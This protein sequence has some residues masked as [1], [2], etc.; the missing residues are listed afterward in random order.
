MKKN[1][2]TITVTIHKLERLRSIKR[3]E[4]K[5]RVVLREEEVFVKKLT[6]KYEKIL[7]QK[8]EISKQIKILRIK[9]ETSKV[10][11]VIGT[12]SN[13]IFKLEKQEKKIEK[14]TKK[15]KLTIDLITSQ[16][17]PSP[18]HSLTETEKSIVHILKSKMSKSIITKMNKLRI[19]L[20]TLKLQL[21]H[22]KTLKKRTTI[23]TRIQKIIRTIKETKTELREVDH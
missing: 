23:K 17:V 20:I 9:K 13:E 14:R 15:L 2:S 18:P 12:L 21:K 22:T 11:K 8:N 1:I 6:K 7:K 16:V 19:S 4:L 3:V 10:E 5:K